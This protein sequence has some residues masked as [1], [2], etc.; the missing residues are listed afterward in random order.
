M[1]LRQA[2]GWSAAAHLFLLA[3]RPPPGLLPAAEA[4]HPIEVTYISTAPAPRSLTHSR[5]KRSVSPAD[6]RRVEAPDRPRPSV[7]PAQERPRTEPVPMKP[8]VLQTAAPLPPTAGPAASV[9]SLP[10]GVFAAVDH[11]EA[12][13]KH[14]RS[15]LL[16]PSAPVEGA[17]RV[18]LRLTPQGLLQE[19]TV[20]ES[21]DPRLK[22][23]AL[24]DVRRAAPYPRFP[25]K[26]KQPHADYEFLVRYEPK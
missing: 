3:V 6:A 14:L 15:F 9:S 19:A 4:L 5:E 12:I 8:P 13:R 1:S 26:M 24:R 18:R 2:V 10:E 7:Q 17:V 25:G 23:A 16:H 21:S 20:L 22:E 11:K